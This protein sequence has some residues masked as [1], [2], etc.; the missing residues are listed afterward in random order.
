MASKVQRGKRRN[1]RHGEHG[2]ISEV[3]LIAGRFRGRKLQF[4]AAE[5]LRPTLDRI[6]ETVFNWLGSYYGVGGDAAL[7]GVRCLDLFAGTG[8]L[9]VE[10]LSRGAT[11]VS[12]AD[13]SPQVCRQI[14]LSIEQLSA[15]VLMAGVDF[16]LRC[17]DALAT[18]QA[19]A[20]HADQSQ[21]FD[22]IFLDPP[23]GKALL[24]PCLDA[25]N[26]LQ[27]LKTDGLIYFEAE[28][29]VDV[30]S[31]LPPD[32]DLFRHKLAGQLQYGLIRCQNSPK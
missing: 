32:W 20:A 7:T 26:R 25:I 27:L 15:G 21:S 3:R 6:R 1:D 30:E 17:A 11:F 29:T 19:L 2:D 14:S 16:E 13:A 18:M 22:L 23:F 4:A 10:A 8:V 12:F 5:G 24:Q 28:K 9:G 31:T